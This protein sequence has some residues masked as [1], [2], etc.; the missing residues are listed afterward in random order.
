MSDADGGSGKR[1]S[2]FT[3]FCEGDTDPTLNKKIRALIDCD[4][5]YI[6]YLDEDLYVEWSFNQDSPGGFDDALTC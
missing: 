6:V 5:D 4:T 1:V 2:D 3:P